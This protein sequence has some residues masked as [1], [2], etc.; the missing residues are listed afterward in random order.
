MHNF[1]T[2][3]GTKLSNFGTQTTIAE[4]VTKVII[5]KLKRFKLVNG[6]QYLYRYYFVCVSLFGAMILQKR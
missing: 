5:N 3:C 4:P 2:E 6:W 1:C